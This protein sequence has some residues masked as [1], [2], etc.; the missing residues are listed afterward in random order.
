MK[1]HDF[2]ECNFRTILSVKKLIFLTWNEE[3]MEEKRK[4]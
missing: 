3:E 4:E 2:M 1:V